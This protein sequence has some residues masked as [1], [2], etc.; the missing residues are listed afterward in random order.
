M[1]QKMWRQISTSEFYLHVGSPGPGDMLVTRT[2]TVTK[3]DE[4]VLTSHALKSALAWLAPSL[5]PF[6]LSLI[7]AFCL[8][9]MRRSPLRSLPLLLHVSLGRA[10]PYLTA[11]VGAGTEKDEHGEAP[12]SPEFWWKLIISVALVLIGGVFAG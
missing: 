1:V 9:C 10:V 5:R 7:S 4:R 11:A 6:V 2:V 8:F 12:G 3:R